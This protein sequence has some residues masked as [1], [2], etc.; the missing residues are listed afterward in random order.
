[1]QKTAKNTNS[2]NKKIRSGA[3]VIKEYQTR[4]DARKRIIIRGDAAQ[5]YNVKQYANGVIVM[6]P[7]TLE[8]PNSISE[9][10]LEM[11]YSS[12]LNFKKNKVSSDFD[13]NEAI[14]LFEDVED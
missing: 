3:T 4:I 5:Y 2:K 10:S 6:E 13:L 11:I 14:S 9:K 12:A 8:R 7:R 1:M